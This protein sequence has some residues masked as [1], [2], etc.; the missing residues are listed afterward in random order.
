MLRLWLM[1]PSQE[2]CCLAG[3]APPLFVRWGI[4]TLAALATLA[5][6]QVSFKRSGS[7]GTPDMGIV[8]TL[9]EVV[10]EVASACPR[11]YG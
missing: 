3:W 11:D 1:R 7:C 10:A 9:G 6:R 5:T 2:P 4:A 8:G